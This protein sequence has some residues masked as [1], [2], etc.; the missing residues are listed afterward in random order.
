M[1]RSKRFRYGLLLILLLLGGGLWTYEAY[2]SWREASQ[3]GVIL[4]AASL[5]GV[6]P[7]L[8]KAVVWRESRFNPRARG[9]KGEYGLM[10][11]MPGTADEFLR[12]EKLTLAGREGLYDPGLNTRA[13][14]WYLRR[15]HRRYPAADDAIPYTLADYNAGRGNVLRWAQG[16]AAT[17]SALF[18]QQITYPST[19]DYVQAVMR[20]YQRYRKTFPPPPPPKGEPTRASAG[21]E[22]GVGRSRPALVASETR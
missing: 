15:L 18:I 10:Q 11:L 9:T 5:Y 1:P 2:W 21:R 22:V 6:E 3:D 16:A 17:N 14:T 12:A 20:R 4:Q 7:A 19:R 13:G 8:V